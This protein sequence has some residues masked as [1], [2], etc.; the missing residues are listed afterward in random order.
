MSV[1]LWLEGQDYSRHVFIEILSCSWSW[2]DLNSTRLE[3]TDL[4]EKVLSDLL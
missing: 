1:L 4:L 2:W 3:L